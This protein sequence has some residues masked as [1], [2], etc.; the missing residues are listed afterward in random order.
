MFMLRVMK[1]AVPMAAMALLWSLQPARAAEAESAGK[2]SIT[3]TVVDSEGKAV[4][5]AMVR[6]MKPFEGGRKRPQANRAA[7]HEQARELADEKPTK[8]QKPERP[9]RGERPK[10]VAT[11]TTDAEGKFTM[12]DVPEGEYMVAAMVRGQGRARQPVTIKVGEAVTVELKLEQRPGGAGG[13]TPARKPK[14][15]AIE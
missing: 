12:N 1:W 5:G 3:G 4:S 9:A 15:G 6:L 14:Q 2:G 8:P 10:P 11:A 13:E 7:Q